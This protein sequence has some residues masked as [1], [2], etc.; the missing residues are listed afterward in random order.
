MI[1]GERVLL[2]SQKREPSN[3]EDDQEQLDIDLTS[4]GKNQRYQPAPN[5]TISRYHLNHIVY[6]LRWVIMAFKKLKTKYPP[7]CL[8]DSKMDQIAADLIRRLHVLLRR[9]ELRSEMSRGRRVS[10]NLTEAGRN[11]GL[12]LGL[13]RARR[14]QSAP[15]RTERIK[16][17]QEMLRFVREPPMISTSLQPSPAESW[18]HDRFLKDWSQRGEE[19]ETDDTKELCETY[20]GEVNQDSREEDQQAPAETEVIEVCKPGDGEENAKDDSEQEQA[21]VVTTEVIEVQS[22]SGSNSPDDGNEQLRHHM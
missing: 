13:R 4:D 3:E 11:G 14:A 8:S 16:F 22:S 10:R 1:G 12:P 18:D 19:E 5:D 7:L 6:T 20:G 15:D 21:P 17:Y 9:E 2:G